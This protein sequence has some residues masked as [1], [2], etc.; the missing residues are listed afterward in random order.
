MALYKPIVVRKDEKLDS[1]VK[2]LYRF[3]EDLRFTFSNLDQD[4]LDAGTVNHMNQRNQKLQSIKFDSGEFQMS[5]ADY[6]KEVYAKL[7]QT[8]EKIGFLV[9]KGKVAETMISRME[10]YGEHIALTTGHVTVDANNWNLDKDGNTEFSGEIVGGTI[11]IGNKFLVTED[12]N[13][14]LVG[15]TEQNFADGI[16]KLTVNGSV[17]IED[18]DYYGAAIIH[19][20]VQCKSTVY[21][22][23]KATA[24]SFRYSSDARLK[25]KVREIERASEVVAMMQPKRWRFKGSRRPGMGFVAQDMYRIQEDLGITAVIRQGKYLKL[26]YMVSMALFVKAIQENQERMAHIRERIERRTHGSI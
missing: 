1:L 10:L 21:C 11:A 16:R 18:S 20:P 23:Y 7:E 25:E 8:E 9:E 3:S 15:D 12:G 17:D 22:V 2:K 13:A 24:K 26:N 19:G 14:V 6:E 4:N 5:F